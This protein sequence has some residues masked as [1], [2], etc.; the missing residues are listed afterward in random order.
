MKHR[1][2]LLFL[3]VL[4]AFSRPLAAAAAEPQVVVS[5]KP[6]HSLV[7]GLMAGIAE[8]HLLI[9]G[10]GSPHG[11]SLRPSEARALNAADLVVWVGPELE[12][13]L[14]KALQ[15][16]S[17]DARNLQLA[18]RMPEMLLPARTG[19]KWEEHAEAHGE[20]AG[21]HGHE[22]DPHL[23]L[24]IPQ[25]KRV[26]ELAEAALIAVD[27]AH[28]AAYRSNAALLQKRLAELQAELEQRLA[29]VKEIPY[30][31][32]HD[33]FQ[34]FENTFQLNAVAAITLDPE[35]KPGIRRI[36]EIR[37]QIRRLDARCVFSEPQFEPR[38]IRTVVENTGAAT[39]TL[40][41]VG[42]ELAAGPD[43]YF[44]LMRNLA[45]N[46]VTGLSQQD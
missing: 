11:Y 7:A 40:D 33:A 6:I 14:E 25:A 5:I 31:V 37:E 19:G 29:S 4:L 44:T 24:G 12:S 36:L 13:F 9:A 30:I 16:L 10:G 17:G 23:W 28:A 45:T 39:G 46:L 8:P 32:F 15:S 27:P 21:H 1:L 18:D 20:E 34:Y 38:L 26:V 2:P 41:P 43:A 22:F 3:A 42:A 35:R